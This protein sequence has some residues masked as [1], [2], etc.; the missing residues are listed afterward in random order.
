MSR[1]PVNATHVRA[2]IK[3]VASGPDDEV[4]KM[5]PGY[6]YD[7]GKGKG[8][9]GRGP[10]RA[11]DPPGERAESDRG[12]ARGAG[13]GPARGAGRGLLIICELCKH[14]PCPSLF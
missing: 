10:R 8:L 2:T 3:Q 6:M 7:V 14:V 5:G 9:P 11:G 1:K 12:P 4:Y 13:R